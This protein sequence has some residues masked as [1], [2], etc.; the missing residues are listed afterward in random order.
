MIKKDESI[1]SI[2]QSPNLH[3]L[4]NKI[5]YVSVLYK[6][7]IS[8]LC[9]SSERTAAVMRESRCDFGSHTAAAPPIFKG[10]I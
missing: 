10:V 9:W 8:T 2:A 4:D 5:D 1:L 3:A 6:K 7:A